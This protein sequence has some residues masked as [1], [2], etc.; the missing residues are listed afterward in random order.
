MCKWLKIKINLF[1]VYHSET[2]SQSEQINQDVKQ[3]LW[4][5][6]NYMQDNWAKWLLMIEFSDNNNAFSATS[7]SLFYL[8]KGF[9][10]RMSFSL[11]ETT[12]ESTHE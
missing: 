8:N 7:L 5:Y 9:H 11:N 10:S 2:D 6:C 1:I 12:Y 3:G 4:T